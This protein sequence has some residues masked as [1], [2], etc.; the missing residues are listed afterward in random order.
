MMTKTEKDL[1]LE[2]LNS[3]L[4]SPHR[5]LNLLRHI[6]A[7]MIE[8]D[9]IFYG[10]LAVWYQ[11]NGEV[12][13][14]KELFISFLLTSKISAHREA[15]FQ[16]LQGLAPYQVSRVVDFLKRN[17]GKLPRSTRTAVT[18]YLRQRE[19]NPKQFD[20]AA[21]RARKAMK[22]LYASLHIKPSSRADAIL[23][24]NRP[25]EDSLAYA[26]KQLAK[27]ESA[28]EQARLIL[29]HR[30]PFTIAVGAVAKITPSVMVA[31]L[32]N[33]TPQEVINNLN[34]LKK[35]GALRH[36]E[37]REVVEAK[38]KLAGSDKRVSGYKAK[39]ALEQVPVDRKLRESLN[40][41]TETQISKHGR[42]LRDTALLVDKSSSMEEAIKIG[43]QLAAMISWA[44]DAKLEVYAFD[45]IAYPIKARGSSL[46]DWEIA[47]QLVRASGCTS[48]GSGL[49]VLRSKRIA[50]EQI[51]LVTDEGENMDPYFAP[52][53]K[54]Y[55]KEMNLRPE[56]IIVQVGHRWGDGMERKLRDMQAP[57]QTYKFEGDYYALPNL[58]PYL[59]RKS[60]FELLMEIMEQPLPIRKDLAQREAS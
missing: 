35:R 30:I 9:P 44:T 49:E 26:L 29:N 55:C 37:V 46:A 17:L 7:E 41:V 22:H 40:S 57:L 23:F 59:T 45:S 56:I 47:F 60:R 32:A 50:V 18:R 3:L 58:M 19:A 38:L 54:K 36:P 34:A 1:R 6:H 2:L 5:K 14:H 31:L 13:D 27:A 20:R 15:G 48:I 53:Y 8:K 12:R 43:K 51:V 25:P 42:I 21:I 24:K 39:V 33:M 52:T 4:T 28:Q 10:H 11:N 16:L